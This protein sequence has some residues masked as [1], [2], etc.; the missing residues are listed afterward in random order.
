M[1]RHELL[2]RRILEW[3]IP[4]VIL[5]SPLP[6]ASVLG[7][8]VLVIQLAVIVMMAAYLLM[9]EKPVLGEMM[10]K[11]LKWPV[12]LFSGLFG[13]I[14][15]QVIP[16]PVFLVKVLSPHTYAF[17]AEYVGGFAGGKFMSLSLMPFHTLGAGL[18]LLTYFLL[19]F[20][21]IKTVTRIQQVRRILYVLVGM[22]IFQ[23]FYG[24]FELF[25]KNPR[26]LFYRKEFYLNDLTGTFVNRNHV[27]GM[28]EMVI[29]LAVALIL[30]RTDLLGLGG[31]KLK[32][33]LL[34]FTDQANYRVL[35][36][37]LGVVLMTLA[38]IFTRSRSGIFLVALGL[39]LFLELSLLYGGRETE[40]RKGIKGYFKITAVVITL[41]ALYMGIDATLQRFSIDKL[42][43]EQRPVFWGQT[44]EIV[45]DFPVLG[46][47]LGTFTALYPAYDKSGANFKVSHAHNDYLEYLSELGIVGMVLLLGGILLL[48]GQAFLIWRERRHPE[49]KAIALGG[50]IAVMAILIHGITDFN[51]QIPANMVLFAVVLPLTMVTAFF[52]ADERGR[53]L[54]KGGE[55]KVEA[56][57][58]KS[59]ARPRKGAQFSR[60][61]AKGLALLG[62]AI[63]ALAAVVSYWNHHL[64]A[65]ALKREDPAERIMLL[66]KADR[67]YPFND[68]VQLELGRAYF[69]RGRN[70]IEDNEVRD[71]ALKA[72]KALY[73]RALSLNPASHAAHFQL[74][75]VLLFLE[76]LEPGE[77]TSG[78]D[79]FKKAASLAGPHRKVL[80]ET[81]LDLMSR[82][83]EL[84]ENDRAFTVETL[85]KSILSVDRDSLMTLMTFW[86]M[87]SGDYTVMEQILPERAWVFRL[88][89]RFLGEKAMKP[90]VRR[91]YLAAA[92]AMDFKQAGEAFKKAEYDYL[93]KRIRKA[94][95]E[96]GSCL[97]ILRRIRFYQDLGGVQLID[98]SEFDRIRKTALLKLA[99]CGLRQGKGIK[100]V[101]EYLYRYL[102]LEDR[103]EA[104]DELVDFLIKRKVFSEQQEAGGDS[105]LDA[106]AFRLFLYLQQNRFSDI[107]EYGRRLEGRFVTVPE[108]QEK[109]YARVLRYIGEAYMGSDFIYDAE[110]S[111]QKSLEVDPEGL[112]TWMCLRELYGRINHE[113][114]L[115][116]VGARIGELVSEAE[117]TLAARVVGRGG[118][119]LEAMQLDGGRKVIEIRLAGEGRG[120]DKGIGGQVPLVTVVF[121][122]RVKK[123]GFVA[124]GK[125]VFSVECLVGRN[126]LEI[127]PVN[128]A[129]RLASIKWQDAGGG[130]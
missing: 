114:G 65:R 36:L 84:D 37:G 69:E 40:R 56:R 19:G 23:A 4:A 103:R 34:H 47:G 54:K 70:N 60:S 82:W 73:E 75:K 122:G 78:D 26:L 22:G 97:N 46:S 6:K 68:E 108:E 25:N 126:V 119:F 117:T 45:G 31:M 30:A 10:R 67:I 16:L 72:A 5:F 106:V 32:E 49:V 63:F 33:K 58:E 74:A 102:E 52:R 104:V 107:I 71:E 90:A 43:A 110:D 105:D 128:R 77:K 18:E 111:L 50:M 39:F 116:E 27:S 99:K 64:Y 12:Y 38:V 3:G 8:A 81:G 129:V 80:F 92:E 100:D 95:S 123:D 121:N 86:E 59:A 96:Y 53:I 113:A 88:F 112:E 83:G 101:K 61:G 48:L 130:N 94:E 51:L 118:R 24:F 79:Y 28:L 20:L 7:W 120:A 125:L 87:N 93:Y 21:V 41:I 89:A 66:K 109:S 124:E 115:I 14:F 1:E 42:L 57:D 55:A 29:P 127:F 62:L 98:E 91:H 35:L 44:A 11:A 2:R 13:V 9:G 17:R 15:I 85:R 76:Y